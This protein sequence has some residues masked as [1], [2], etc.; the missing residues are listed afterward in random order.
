GAEGVGPRRGVAGATARA[1]SRGRRADYSPCREEELPRR[2]AARDVSCRLHPE[3]GREAVGEPEPVIRGE[4]EVAV[5]E[6]AQTEVLALPAERVAVVVKAG[7][8][9]RRGEVERGRQP[10]LPAEGI[11][12]HQRRPLLPDPNRKVLQP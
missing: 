4:G 3:A 1:A 12:Q 9:Q 7:G 8:Q 6:T 5:V 10:F 2:P 11:S